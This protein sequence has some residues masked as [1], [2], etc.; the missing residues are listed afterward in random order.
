MDNEILK[1]RSRQ[2]AMISLFGFF[3]IIMAFA[4]A[5]WKL[6]SLN[7]VIALKSIEINALD[8]TIL[9]QNSDIEVKQKL[10]N[11]LV[12][13]INKLRDPRIQPKVSAVEIPGVKDAQSR[14][15]FDFTLWITSSQYT[16]NRISKV[17]YHF[18]NATY[19]MKDRESNDHS[20]GF[21][22]SYRGW[23]CLS[24]IKI[25]VQYDNGENETLYFDMCDGLGW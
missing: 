3:I 21:L 15:I 12:D 10:V 7:E 20:N 2:G 17:S 18:N 24:V 9:K 11:D 4:F 8:S 6:N 14:Q 19:L 5:S 16:L 22:I 1:K 13:E 23:G 25:T